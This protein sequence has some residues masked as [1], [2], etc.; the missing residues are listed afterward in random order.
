M[1]KGEGGGDDKSFPKHHGSSI[2]PPKPS[3]LPA[4]PEAEAKVTEIWNTIAKSI[5]DYKTKEIKLKQAPVPVGAWR[6][7]RI[8]VSSTF[9]D[10][11]NEREVLV[12]KVC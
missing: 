7:V 9:N 2:Q 10:F 5:E 12:K 6:T 11:F 1:K 8:F 4:D 3:S